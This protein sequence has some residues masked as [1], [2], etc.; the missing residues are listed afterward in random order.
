MRNLY[1]CDL[2]EHVILYF[3]WDHELAMSK[4]EGV[5]HWENGTNTP[6][7]LLVNGLGRN[8]TYV[9][10]NNQQIF[11]PTARFH[12]R[13][14]NNFKKFYVTEITDFSLIYLKGLKI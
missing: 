14:V 9:N 11:T 13:K 3:D 7:S 12:V 4:Y 2:D 6:N 10:R 8:Q 1:D 5:L